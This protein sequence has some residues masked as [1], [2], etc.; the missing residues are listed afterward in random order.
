MDCFKGTE[1][2]K[3]QGNACNYNYYLI[4]DLEIPKNNALTPIMDII[5]LSNS[6]INQ[7]NI[8]GTGTFSF[9]KYQN[10]LNNKLEGVIALLNDDSSPEEEFEK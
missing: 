5:V 8:Y 9:A 2:K 4:L 6:L 7:K 1:F 3:I 10:K